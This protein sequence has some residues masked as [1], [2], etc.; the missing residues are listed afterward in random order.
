MPRRAVQ[1]AEDVVDNEGLGRKRSKG[2]YFTWL[3]SGGL[4]LVLAKTCAVVRGGGVDVRDG[5][6]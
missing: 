2:M 3:V 5:A 4:L 1:W 6:L